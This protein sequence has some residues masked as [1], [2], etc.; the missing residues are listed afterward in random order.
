MLKHVTENIYLVEGK[1]DGRFPFCHSVL[2]RDRKSALIE[3][4]CGREILKEIEKEYT[5]DMVIFSHIHPDHCAGSSVFPAERLWGPV[6]SKGT[7]GNIRRMAERLVIKGLRGDWISYMKKVPELEDFSVGNHFANKHV[8]DFGD[9]VMEAVHTP[10]HT[11]DHY[12]FYF[13]NEKI[14]LTTDIDFSSFGPW[15]GNPESDIDSFIDSVNRV[16]DYDMGIVISSHMGVIK[17]G[18]GKAFDAFL[19]AFEKREERILDFLDKPRS[20]EDFVEK[21]MIYKK[22]PYLASVLTFFEAQMTE[23]H[24][25][26][27]ISR[28]LVSKVGNKFVR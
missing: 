24:L 4:G 16:K 17:N 23:K 6:E 25:N 20:I 18:I 10:G 14:M 11:E 21:A 9:T 1:G 3:T 8:F 2:I 7:T 19:N 26:R 27:L 5:P 12:C 22:F 13:P 28:G 15:Y